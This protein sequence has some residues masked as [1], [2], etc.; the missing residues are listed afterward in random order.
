M[1]NYGHSTGVHSLSD[2]PKDV[3][4]QDSRCTILLE[5]KRLLYLDKVYR[6]GRILMG[7]LIDCQDR[8]KIRAAEKKFREGKMYLSES[9][10][11]NKGE[12]TPK[13]KR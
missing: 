3:L 13:W 10:S 11:R 7:L 8:R 4:V 12:N 1:K 2:L 5:R 9:K 6:E